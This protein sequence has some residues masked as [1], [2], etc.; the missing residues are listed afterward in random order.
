MFIF[1]TKVSS[2]CLGGYQGKDDLRTLKS[3]QS[4][5]GNLLSVF[6]QETTSTGAN[7][8]CACVILKVGKFHF[9]FLTVGQEE[10]IMTFNT[11]IHDF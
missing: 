8:S 5:L 6:Q 1:P 3:Q 7:A 10:T 4:W 9:S 11:D 2:F